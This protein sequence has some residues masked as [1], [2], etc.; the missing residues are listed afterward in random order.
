MFNVQE[1]DIKTTQLKAEVLLSEPSTH[2]GLG[3][4]ERIERATSSYSNESER[5]LLQERN[6]SRQYAQIYSVRIM[7]MRKKLAVAARRKWGT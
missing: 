1:F 3:D 5:F 4:E 2:E 7:A 6:F